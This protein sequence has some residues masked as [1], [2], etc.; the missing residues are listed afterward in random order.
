MSTTHATAPA[1]SE[2]SVP[3][4]G[5]VLGSVAL[6]AV[7]V[8]V[9][10][11]LWPASA[12]EEARDDGERLGEAVGQLYYAD[13]TD[14]V[15]AALTEVRDATA[16]S[17][18]HAGDRVANQVDEQADALAGAADGFVGTVTADDEFTADLYQAELEYS[19]DD[20]YNQATDFREEAPEVE[21]AF[22]EGVQDGLPAELAK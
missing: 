18:D 12:A 10:V 1:R 21:Q 8:A 6:V 15:D 9:A 20:L 17:V 5:W 3:V 13:T 19:V 2:R 14:E 22:W 11:A 7:L 16:T 4:L